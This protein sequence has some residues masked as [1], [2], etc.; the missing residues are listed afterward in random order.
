MESITLS[1]SSEERSD[2]NKRAVELGLPAE[3]LL[4]RS[5]KQVLSPTKLSFKEALEY[6]FQKNAELYKRL[7]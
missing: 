3:E 7:A 6:T 4:R 1:L 2:L 5:L